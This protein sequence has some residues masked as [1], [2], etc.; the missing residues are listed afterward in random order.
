[1]NVRNGLNNPGLI[2]P[3][4]G[5]AGTPASPP[6]AQAQQDIS[7]GGDQAHWSKAAGQIAG[8][9]AE[10]EVRLDKVA[11]IQNALASGTYNVAPQAVAQKLIS[12]MLAQG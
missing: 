12:S 9:A 7:L 4:A 3:S 1:M 6:L 2:L 10:P 8:S 5:V 11:S